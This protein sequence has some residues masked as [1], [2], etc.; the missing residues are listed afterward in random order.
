MEERFK[1]IPGVCMC[2]VTGLSLSK[3]EQIL[4]RES[5]FLRWDFPGKNANNWK[6]AFT[7]GK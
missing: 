1:H 3:K 4:T 6:L 2:L 7:L 5:N